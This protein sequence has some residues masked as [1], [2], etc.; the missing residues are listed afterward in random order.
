MLNSLHFDVANVW[1]E[2]LLR[3]EPLLKT[4]GLYNLTAG[5]NPEEIVNT[6]STVFEH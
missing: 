5:T 4:A 6:L 2:N 3:I 1:Q